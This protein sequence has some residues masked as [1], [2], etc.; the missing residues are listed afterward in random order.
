M[1]VKTVLQLTVVC[2]GHFL[3]RQENTERGLCTEKDLQTEHD[4]STFVSKQ[5][6]A[7][8]PLSVSN[9]SSQF[10][11]NRG[12]GNSAVTTRDT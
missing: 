5:E 12:A 2:G 11:K 1:Y 9:A 7:S 8:L 10:Y 3:N 6:N 4:E